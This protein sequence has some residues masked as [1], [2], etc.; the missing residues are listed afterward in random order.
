MKKET[1]ERRTKTKTV[2]AKTGEYPSDI[3]QFSKL[4]VLRKIFEGY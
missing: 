3:P 2:P 1:T 4:R